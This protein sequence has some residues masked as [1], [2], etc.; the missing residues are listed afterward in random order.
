MT[1]DSS[2]IV[3]ALAFEKNQYDTHTLPAVLLLVRRLTNKTP[4]IGIVDRGYRGKSKINDTLI[5][6][7]RLERKNA[8][9]EVLGL[10]RKRFG[11]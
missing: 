7:P 10:A 3:G 4:E 8:A 11:R 5:V 6:I 2:I 9:K 1:R